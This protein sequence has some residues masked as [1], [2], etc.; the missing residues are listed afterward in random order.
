MNQKTLLAIIALLTV[1]KVGT[2]VD[3]PNISINNEA[4]KFL[5]DCFASA[6][7]LVILRKQVRDFYYNLAKQKNND[8]SYND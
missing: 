3:F 5:T 8:K 2:C 7:D 6:N 4:V 1:L